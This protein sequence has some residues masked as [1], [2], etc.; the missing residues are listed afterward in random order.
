MYLQ[1]LVKQMP[2]SKIGNTA[3]SIKTFIFLEPYALDFTYTPLFLFLPSAALC[4]SEFF[5]S[6][7]PLWWGLAK[8]LVGSGWSFPTLP[9]ILVGSS[10]PSP[11]G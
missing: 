1:S 3:C 6:I 7:H 11:R 4:A 2:Y 10:F 5:F 9:S 8:H